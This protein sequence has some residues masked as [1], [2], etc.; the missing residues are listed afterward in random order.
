MSPYKVQAAVAGS[1][2]AREGLSGRDQGRR[3]R[4]PD[5]LLQ[6]PIRALELRQLS[7]LLDQR[8]ALG[9]AAPAPS[10]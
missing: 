7:P 5:S 8:A 3:F 4:L 2:P 6:R 9:P 1:F 10:A